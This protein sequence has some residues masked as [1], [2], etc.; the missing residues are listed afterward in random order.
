MNANAHANDT[1]SDPSALPN[2]VSPPIMSRVP[3]V[4]RAV[5]ARLALAVTVSIVGLIAIACGD[6]EEVSDS[7]TPALTAAPT[8]NCPPPSPTGTVP[9]IEAKQY[10]QRPPMTIDPA[11]VYIGHV[12]TTRGHFIIELLPQVAPEHVNSFVFLAREK[13]YNGT[14]FHRVEKDPEPFVIQGGDPT[15]TGQGGPGYNVPLEASAE[16]FVRSVVGMARAQD[17]DSAGSQWFVMLGDAPHLNGGY[18]AFG[19]VRQ[20]ME[21]VDCIEVGDAIIALDIQE[22]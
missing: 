4:T 19:R 5:L 14:V 8:T 15:G 9:P 16:P 20:G 3:A 12:Y 22:L 6:D 13:F 2:V 1:R 21:I 17:P 18:T 7:P 10:D 11:K